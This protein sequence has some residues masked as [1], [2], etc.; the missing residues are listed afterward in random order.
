MQQPGLDPLQG[1]VAQVHALQHA[2]AVV[3]D[4]HVGRAQ[5]AFEGFAS[6]RRLEVQGDAALVAVEGQ[7]IALIAPAEAGL[8]AAAG[9]LHLD[10]VGPQRGQDEARRG[11][12]HDVAELKHSD[13]VKHGV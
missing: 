2:G 8:V 11:A 7:E 12:G 6:A 10:D 4:E 9:P 1:V 5:E 13:A 3:V